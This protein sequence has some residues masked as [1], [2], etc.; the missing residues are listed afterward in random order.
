MDSNL[1]A[2][3]NS[4]TALASFKRAVKGNVIGTVGVGSTT[5]SI[6]SSAL[7]P[8]GSVSTQ[9]KG[10]IITFADDT[11]TAALRGQSTDITASS[12]SATPTFTVTAL[13][14]APVSGDTFSIT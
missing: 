11:T 13:T 5:T 12:A 7:A 1:G 3:D 10:R 8:A 9:F 2:I 4:T 14:T 6:V